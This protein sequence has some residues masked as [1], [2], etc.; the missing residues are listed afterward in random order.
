MGLDQHTENFIDCMRA[1]ATPRFDVRT[2]SLAAVNAHLG[3][4][5]LRTGDALDWNAKVGRFESG[6]KRAAGAG[7]SQSMAVAG[8]VTASGQM[9]IAG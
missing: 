7:L 2:A 3:N 8:R 9:G 1:R 5:A 4:I 6:R